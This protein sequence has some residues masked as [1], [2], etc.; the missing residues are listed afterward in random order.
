MT[1]AILCRDLRKR[2]PARPAPVDAVNGLDLEVRQGECFGL[3]GPNG[4]GK[5]TTI[6]ILEGLLPPTSGEVEVLGRK[7]GQDDEEL[8]QRLGITLQETRL[9][10]KLTVLESLRLFRSFYRQGRPPEEVV[11]EVDLTEKSGSYVGKLSG[12]QRQRLAV[13]CALV[14]EPELLFLDEPTTGLDPQSRRALWDILRAFRARGRTILLT[15]H[16]MDEAER[17]CDRVA[18]VDHGKVI[19]LG[20][21]A[22]LIAQLGGEHLIEFVPDRD[23]PLEEAHLR[24]LPGVVGVRRE[25]E[26]YSLAV[27]APH[28]TVPALLDHLQRDGLGLARLTTRHASLEDVFVTLT[29]RHLRDG[30]E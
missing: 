3:L 11:A 21:P 29:G 23:A 30:G 16:Y 1:P 15:T 24:E 14:G 13:A 17:L 25:E 6:E 19:A 26:V 27:T 9:A 12:G 8:R 7:W 5:T 28:V 10:E 18:V 2:Y 22:E 20:T 4:A